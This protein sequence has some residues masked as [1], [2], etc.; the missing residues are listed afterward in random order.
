[1]L[2]PTQLRL[3]DLFAGAGGMTQGFAA[4]GAYSLVKAVEFDLAAAATYASNF[5][6]DHVYA[7][8]I[9]DWRAEGDLPAAD[10]II[11]GPPCQGFSALGKQAK[12]DARNKLWIEYALTIQS[13]RPRYFIIEN[14]TQFLD[15]PEFR[16]LRRWTHRGG[17]LSEYTLQPHILNAA[18]FGSFQS[19]KRA[20]VIGR[21]RTLPRLPKPV[22]EWAGKHRTV[23]EAFAEVESRVSS[24]D[25]PD[26][27][28]T[29]R[30]QNFP[31]AFTSTELHLTRDYQS[32]SK[33]RFAVIPPG[34]N[35][36][37]LPDDLKANCWKNHS[38]GSGDVMGR[39]HWEK[40]SVTVRTEFFKP[41]KGR[42][43]HPVEDR[44]IT[45]FEASLLQGFPTDYSWV[46]NKT[47]VARQIGNAVPVDLSTALATLIAAS[48]Q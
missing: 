46:G 17:R 27:S 6:D 5:G 40:P 8:S 29:F 18:D 25:L 43:L 36:F 35:R 33:R 2:V 39:L 11:G 22:G 45:H 10:V 21:L 13:V 41:E 3:I 19:R 38:S 31:G 48:P 30:G 47:Q 28:H 44:A 23:R 14:V 32:L 20:V 37:N 15:S 26:R 9:Q 4:T 24:I 34:G 16:A 42:Y 7:G 1:M 12:S